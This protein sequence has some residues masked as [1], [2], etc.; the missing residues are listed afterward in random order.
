VI[1]GRQTGIASLRAVSIDGANREIAAIDGQ[2]GR[3]LVF[4]ARV[5]GNVAPARELRASALSDPSAVAVAAVDGELW[6]GNNGDASLRAFARTASSSGSGESAKDPQPL[7]VIR[8]AR[9]QLLAVSAIAVDSA[10]REVYVADPVAH[11]VL[12]FDARA[13]GDVAPLRAL[14]GLATQLDRPQALSLPL[15]TDRLQVFNGD[16][17]LLEFP[18]A[19]DGSVPP[20]GP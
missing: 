19:A 10:R 2:S 18:R 9:T 5:P 6:V 14:R 7:R 12:V 16:R 4:D 13:D 8:G 17:R 1:A 3:V 15:G 11:Q 20:T